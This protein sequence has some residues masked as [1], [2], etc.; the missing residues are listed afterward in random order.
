MKMVA[1][2]ASDVYPILGSRRVAYLLLGALCT[3]GGYA[4]MAGSVATKS[5]YIVATLLVAIGFMVQDVVADA[6]SVEVARNDEELGQIQ[7][8][9]RMALLVAAV[10][11][12]YLS[13]WLTAVF[14]TR[15]TFGMAPLLPVLVGLS[16]IVLRRA[17]VPERQ[18]GPATDHPLGGGRARLVVLAG[19]AYAAL[20]VA[21]E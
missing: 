3:L 20:G 12:G 2:V 6:L 5:A 19:L 21:L 1:G 8:L 17:P 14:G 18:P 10:G 15:A 11:V 4:L 16:A 9:G 13:G 7:T